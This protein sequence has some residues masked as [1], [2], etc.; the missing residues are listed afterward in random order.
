MLAFHTQSQGWKKQSPL[1]L[2]E[3]PQH[4]H[5]IGELVGA[6]RYGIY[7]FLKSSGGF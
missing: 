7:S 5:G 3:T 6:S 1:P 4:T 2:G